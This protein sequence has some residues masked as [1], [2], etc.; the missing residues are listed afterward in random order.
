MFPSYKKQE[1]IEYDEEI[2][3]ISWHRGEPFACCGTFCVFLGSQSYKL[4]FW[5][6]PW[7]LALR[8]IFLFYP[9]TL[10]FV[11]VPDVKQKLTK[12]YL[13]SSSTHLLLPIPWVFQQFIKPLVYYWGMRGVWGMTFLEMILISLRSIMYFGGAPMTEWFIELLN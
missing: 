6:P 1:S 8:P 12:S 2:T 9:W 3:R 11:F 10:R 13:S 4:A 5:L 7:R